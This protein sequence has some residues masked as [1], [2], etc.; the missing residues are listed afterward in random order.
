M[1]GT[2]TIDRRA[3]VR[4][5]LQGGL[6]LNLTPGFAAAAWSAVAAAGEASAPR[7]RAGAH[8]HAHAHA[9]A[10]MIARI[11]ETILP[12]SDTPGA[13]DVGVSSWINLVVAEYFS[14]AQRAAFLAGLS[15]IDQLA[16]A[17]FGARMAALKADDLTGVVATL[18][19]ACGSTH[20]T[21]AQRGYVQLKELVIVGYFTSQ[22]VQH[23]LLKIVILPG[24]FDGDVPI[25]PASP[26]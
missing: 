8:A 10:E 17:Q 21:A 26:A 4:A 7:A 3:A 5:L 15:A 2:K 6:A 9:H 23:D 16:L 19:A 25:A 18:D 20:L 11:A 13:T 12:R 14:D 22:P 1:P 24:R